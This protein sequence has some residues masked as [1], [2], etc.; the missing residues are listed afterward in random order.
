MTD[1]ALSDTDSES[2]SIQCSRMLR[3]QLL[4]AS[5]SVAWANGQWVL[6]GPGSVESPNDLP[7]GVV[8]V[9][10]ALD[11]LCIMIHLDCASVA[12]PLVA[13][14]ILRGELSQHQQ[15]HGAW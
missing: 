5:T 7:E 9:L 4:S 3:T 1:T 2:R 8:R 13:W 6:H 15:W 11:R 14:A 12:P 10:T